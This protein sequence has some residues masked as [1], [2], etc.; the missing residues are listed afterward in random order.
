MVNDSLIR[1]KILVHSK[2]SQ[3]RKGKDMRNGIKFVDNGGEKIYQHP[4]R[5]EKRTESQKRIMSKRL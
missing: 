4:Q 1:C 2:G 5:I 3:K